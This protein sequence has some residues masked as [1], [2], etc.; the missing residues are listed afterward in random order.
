MKI[1]QFLIILGIG[2]MGC[3]G[4]GGPGNSCNFLL[5]VGVNL[6]LNL[7]LP[8]YSQLQFI[9]NS[10]YVP[11]GGNKGVIV[12][13]TGTGY[14]AWDASDPNHTPNTCSTLG[15]SGVEATCGCDDGNTYSLFTGQ[16]LNN[17]NLR[18]GLKPYRVTLNGSTLL[19]T[20]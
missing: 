17:G 5:N 2:L 20:N 18:C 4:D 8:Q 14:S 10:V 3:S 16:P 12:I 11:N 9:S 6:S 1:R 15:I 13:N 7:N 19:I